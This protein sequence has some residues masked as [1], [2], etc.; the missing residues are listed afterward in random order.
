MK[1]IKIA[2]VF[3]IFI[4]SFAIIETNYNASEINK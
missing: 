4:S 2:I 1:K 3:L